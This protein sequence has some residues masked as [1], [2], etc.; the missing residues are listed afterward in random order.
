MVCGDL[1]QLPPVCAKP[2][3]TFNDTETIEGFLIMDLRRK[4]RLAELDQVMRQ[5]DEMFLNM[6]NK[7]R[8]GEIDQDVED[9]F[10]LRFFDKYYPCYPGN[11][12][13]E[14]A[15]VKRHNDNQLKHI[16]GQ[17]ITIPAKD[18][19]PKKSKIS[20]IREVQNRKQ[21]ET[22]G[23]ASLLELKVNA[24]VMLAAS[25]NIKDRLINRQMETVKHK[26]IK[27]MK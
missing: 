4:F 24:R 8:V 22:G 23:L 6:L 13:T 7:I 3:F 20:Y 15:P 9:V 1:C 14:N 16:P 5:D 26:E 17:L 25:I 27:K 19:V 12:F 10:K 18:E 21:F 2:V 11:I